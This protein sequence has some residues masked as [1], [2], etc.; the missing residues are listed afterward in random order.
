MGFD[1]LGK[2]SIQNN[3]SLIR[4]VLTRHF[5][6]EKRFSSEKKK[7]LSPF[8]RHVADEKRKQ[9]ELLFL[10]LFLSFVLISIV[11]VFLLTNI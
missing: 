5:R 4:S 2:Q 3:R 1:E 7:D 11:C 6:N 9:S 8:R 10:V